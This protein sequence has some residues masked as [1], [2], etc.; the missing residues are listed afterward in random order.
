M[1]GYPSGFLILWRSSASFCFNIF[2]PAF[3]PSLYHFG[4]WRSLANFLFDVFRPAPFSDPLLFQP[5]ALFNWLLF[6]SASLHFQVLTIL[7]CGALCCHNLHVEFPTH[8]GLLIL[9][10]SHGLNL[11]V[12]FAYCLMCT[13]VLLGFWSC[14]LGM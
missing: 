13:L 6:H 2:Q 12:I 5:V 14:G 11:S 7:I 8:L 3:V 9:S 10:V 4:S 1:V